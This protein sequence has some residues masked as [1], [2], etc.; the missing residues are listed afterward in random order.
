MLAACAAQ[1]LAA[2]SSNAGAGTALQASPPAVVVEPRLPK[3]PSDVAAAAAVAS[4]LRERGLD[5]T[6]DAQAYAQAR[7]SGDAAMRLGAAGTEVRLE[8]C[9]DFWVTVEATEAV[10]EP[11]AVYGRKVVECSCD[12]KA[13]VTFHR[14]AVGTSGQTCHA[15]SNPVDWNPA[16]QRA[17]QPDGIG[18]YQSDARDAAARCGADDAFS[19]IEADWKQRLRNPDARVVVIIG[20]LPSGET[21]AGAERLEDGPASCTLRMESCSRSVLESLGT[22]MCER[23]GFAEVHRGKPA[24]QA[25]SV[26]ARHAG[27]PISLRLVLGVGL[28]VLLLAI[29]VGMVVFGLPGRARTGSRSNRR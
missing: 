14:R 1:G 17:D 2:S 9:P 21:P 13:T 10:S 19:T 26:A 7:A 28:G 5:A 11:R 16:L 22:V 18:A 6:V 27:A 23:P 8:P 12:I 4:R 3:D 29:I 25:E 20:S 24:A 15:T